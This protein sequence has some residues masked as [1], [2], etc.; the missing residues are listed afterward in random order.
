MIKITIKEQD[1]RLLEVSTT[2][3]WAPWTRK[4]C[5]TP[6]VATILSAPVILEVFLWPNPC[7]ILAMSHSFI[8][9]LSV[10]AMNVVNWS[11]VTKNWGRLSRENQMPWPGGN[12]HISTAPSS[13]SVSRKM[14]LGAATSSQGTRKM[15]WKS[16]GTSRAQDQALKKESIQGQWSSLMRFTA[17]S[18]KSL[19]K[20]C[21]FW[22]WT[23]SILDPSGWSSRFWPLHHLQWD[24]RLRLVMVW[25][26]MTI[27][28]MPIT[29]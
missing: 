9:F 1:S 29:K 26:R 3:I 22:V 14:V 10:Y 13:R 27:L 18:R 21:T 6:V 25:D 23:L 11:C 15:V 12:W 2:F 24:L 16:G 17:F 5:V 7:S 28:H 4:W 20:T 19:T 8:S